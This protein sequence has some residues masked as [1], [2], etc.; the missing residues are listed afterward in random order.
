MKW[1]GVAMISI[2]CLGAEEDWPTCD[3][4]AFRNDEIEPGGLKLLGVKESPLGY[5]PKWP[6]AATHEHL[7]QQLREIL[8]DDCPRIFVEIGL[9]PAPGPMQNWSAS[10]LWLR[11]FNH[12]GIVLA[13]DPVDA[14]L[15]HFSD[16]LKQEP[17]SSTVTPG[18][19]QV[20]TVQAGLGIKAAAKAKVFVQSASRGRVAAEDEVKRM[21]LEEEPDMQNALHPCFHVRRHPR[22]PEIDYVAPTRTF[23]NIWKDELSRRHIDF[24]HLNSGA[25]DIAGMLERGFA[26]VLSSRSVTILSLRIDQSWTKGELAKVVSILD[27]HEYFS[28]FR[29]VCHDSSKFGS[30]SYHGPGQVGPTTYLPLS[31]MDLDLILDWKSMPLPQDLIALDLQQPDIFKTVQLGDAQCDADDTDG[32]CSGEEECSGK[33]VGPPERPQLLRVTRS[34][35]RSVTLEWRP[36]PEG[37]TP[38]SYLLRVE[39]G[40][41]EETLGHD[42]F[43]ALTSVQTHTINGLRP[44]VEFSFILR[45]MGFGGESGKVSVTHRTDQEEQVSDSQYEILESMHCGMGAAEEVQPAGPAPGGASYFPGVSEVD[46]CRFRCESNRQCVAFQVNAGNACWLY[47]RKPSD[48]RMSVPRTDVGWWCGVRRD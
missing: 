10:A 18:S 28:M 45:A 2:A 43:D 12:S 24:L 14:Y 21:C 3:N 4:R 31:S 33:L 6:A 22:W 48:Q 32:T 23:D 46:G 11:Y 41:F 44:D 35:S 8:S 47:R 9:Q 15:Q 5:Y 39:P 30:F 36:H 34:S 1:L 13:V 27:K 20:Q 16:N 19:V 7:F 17:S 42:T 38:D 40:A 37:P 26:K 29:L 25:T